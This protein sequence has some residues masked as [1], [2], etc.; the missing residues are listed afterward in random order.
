[1]VSPSSASEVQAVR[2]A[3]VARAIPATAMRRGVLVRRR[4]SLL[5]FGS[6]HHSATA[7]RWDRH[8]PR[9]VRRAPTSSPGVGW[10]PLAR[11]RR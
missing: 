4:I 1:M 9:V 11:R 5:L 8:S 7:G 3:A 6:T 2:A 10:L